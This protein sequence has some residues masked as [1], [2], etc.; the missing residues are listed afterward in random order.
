MEGNDYNIKDWIELV[1]KTKQVVTQWQF[2]LMLDKMKR[3]RR[4]EGEREEEE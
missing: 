3:Y 4:K 1:T 2:H